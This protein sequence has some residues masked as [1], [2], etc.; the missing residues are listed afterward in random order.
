MKKLAK[1]DL[2]LMGSSSNLE[3]MMRMI[4]EKMYWS[5]EEVKPSEQFTCGRKQCYDIVTRNGLRENVVIINE[6]GRY[7]LYAIL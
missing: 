2:R 1:A 6:K 3:D 7:K 5:V 4:K